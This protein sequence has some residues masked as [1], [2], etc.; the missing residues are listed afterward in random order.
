MAHSS[1]EKIPVS[2]KTQEKFIRNEVQQIEMALADANDGKGKSR[3]VLQLETAKRNAEKRLEQ[4]LNSKQKDN[5]IDFEDLGVDYLF[6]DEA[7]NYKNCARR[8]YIR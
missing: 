8:C 2:R 4:L 3:T 7:H 6:I 5:V 1:F